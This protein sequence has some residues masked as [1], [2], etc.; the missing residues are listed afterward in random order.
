MGTV[1]AE[2]DSMRAAKMAL[3]EMQCIKYA[4]KGLDKEALDK[5]AAVKKCKE[6]DFGAVTLDVPALPTKAE[7]SKD[8]S[9]KARC[10]S[11]L[12]AEAK[13]VTDQAVRDG[14]LR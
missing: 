14:T 12:E 7:V 11:F 10:F 1:Q 8:Q 2:A 13:R 3:D 6:K 9:D 4:L 5:T